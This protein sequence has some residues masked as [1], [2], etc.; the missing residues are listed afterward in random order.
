MDANKLVKLREVEFVIRK[1][2]GICTYGRFVDG[3]DWGTCAKHSYTHVKHVGPDRGMS[4]HRSGYC[5]C[6]FKLSD[7][8]VLGKHDEFLEK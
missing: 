4:V 2:C 6:G 3:R 5:Q 1:T 7:G 8:I